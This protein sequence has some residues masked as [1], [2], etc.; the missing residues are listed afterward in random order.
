MREVERI[1]DQM[2]RAHVGDP[3][4]D[5]P[6]LPLLESL[7]HEQAAA[8]P[9]RGGHSVWEIALHL[10]GTQEY[11]VELT[12]GISRPFEPG[13]EWPPVGETTEEAWFA[14]VERFRIGEAEVRRAVSADV[15][16][17]QLG[18]PF[19]DGGTSAY[20]N[21]HGYVQHAVYHAGQISMLKRLVE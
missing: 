19:R 21:L 13:D 7:S 5:V 18:E 10:L 8:K 12:R 6:I 1:V 9:I 4:T 11:I 20:N 3:W 17:E 14:V 16:D 2:E 15:A